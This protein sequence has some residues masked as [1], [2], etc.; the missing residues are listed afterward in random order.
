MSTEPGHANQET[1]TRLDGEPDKRFKEHGGGSHGAQGQGYEEIGDGTSSLVT[2]GTGEDTGVYK[3][4]AHGGQK[5]DGGSDDRV[6]SEHGFGGDRE[7]A[8]AEGQKGGSASYENGGL[9]Q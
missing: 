9:T 4:S 2:E 3:P 5:K 8:S 6:S 1:H 7:R